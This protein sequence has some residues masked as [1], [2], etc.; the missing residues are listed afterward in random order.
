MTEN[1]DYIYDEEKQQMRPKYKGRVRSLSSPGLKTRLPDG[2]GE[3]VE[4]WEGGRFVGYERT[5]PDRRG[6][7]QP[8]HGS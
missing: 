5:R 6:C 3:L 8:F 4:I 1:P 7:K 2:G